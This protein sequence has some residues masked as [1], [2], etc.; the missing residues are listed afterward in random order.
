MLTVC[1]QHCTYDSPPGL[2]KYCL[3]VL[4]ALPAVWKFSLM[5]SWPENLMSNHTRTTV[6]TAKKAPKPAATCH[7]GVM[8]RVSEDTQQRLCRELKITHCLVSYNN[9]DHSGSKREA[10]RQAAVGCIG[11]VSHWH[12]SNLEGLHTAQELHVYALCQ[13]NTKSPAT[14]P[15]PTD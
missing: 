4:I 13:K 3:P 10:S 8:R 2:S 12:F 7:D 6:I 5:S 15:Q 1:T 11:T 9:K 14:T